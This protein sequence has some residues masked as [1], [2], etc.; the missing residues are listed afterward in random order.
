MKSSAHQGRGAER[1]QREVDVEK[2][3]AIFQLFR[4]SQV[5]GF[6][7]PRRCSPP[8]TDPEHLPREEH[9]GSA[10]LQNYPGEGSPVGLACMPGRKGQ[11][12]IKQEEE[13][14]SI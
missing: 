5:P 11:F 12:S 1:A 4:A 7:T 8:N 3:N 6:A 2:N 14:G 13:R 10:G 9:L